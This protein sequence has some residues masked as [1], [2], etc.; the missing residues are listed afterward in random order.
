[1]DIA[2]HRFV[3]GLHSRETRDSIRQMQAMTIVKWPD[4]LRLA[5]AREV[6]TNV[7]PRPASFAVAPE[8]ATSTGPQIE[9][10]QNSDFS[11]QRDF[12]PRQSGPRSS[13]PRDRSRSRSKGGRASSKY[14]K[15]YPQSSGQNGNFSRGP[16]PNR[17]SFSRG[18]TSGNYQNN[19]NCYSNN[20]SQ[21]GPVPGP[22]Q[23]PQQAS[24][25]APHPRSGPSG[26]SRINAIANLART[27][28]LKTTEE[29]SHECRQVRLTV[30]ADTLVLEECIADTG[31][32]RTIINK[33]TYEMLE[34]RPDLHPWSSDER[35]YAVRDGEL[36]LWA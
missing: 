7:D 8:G 12:Q 9:N 30:R 17:R 25:G 31:S 3:A 33:D 21:V 27:C 19:Q 34:P 16:S 36:P 24:R 4:A 14:G 13:R 29:R 1:M 6:S 2:I 26:D 32:S 5:Q 23:G 28:A 35:L 18:R 10:S 11:D 20:S 15:N 22:D